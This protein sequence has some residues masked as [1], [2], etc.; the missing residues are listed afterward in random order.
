MANP[1]IIFGAGASYDYIRPDARYN[2]KPQYNSPITKDIFSKY[3]I[4]RSSPSY[5]EKAK[6]LIAHVVGRLS[7][8]NTFE[9]ILT[10]RFRRLDKSSRVVSERIA[11][12]FYLQQLFKVV[13]EEIGSQR[14]NNYEILID[15]CRSYLEENQGENIIC[16]TFNYDTLLDQA[17]GIP[18]APTDLEPYINQNI[19]LIKLH[20]SSNWS[21]YLGQTDE[22][23]GHEYPFQY[24]QDH[25]EIVADPQTTNLAILQKDSLNGERRDGKLVLYYPAIAIPLQGKDQF[26]CPADHVRALQ[27]GIETTD[28]IL[29]IGWRGNDDLLIN[30]IKQ[31]KNTK[32]LKILIVSSKP[33]TAREIIGQNLQNIPN[34]EVVASECF[35]FGAF[36]SSPELTSFFQ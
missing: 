18:Y 3:W 32:H 13:S 25:P 5:T 14:G 9:A 33:N 20:G 17:I 21:Y 30:A 8:T 1:I 2:H 4:E 12:S 6:D 31:R 10:Q 28:R 29:I 36:V 35:G 23:T 22:T 16:A 19:P 34:A 26:V 7:N 15:E 11:L 27:Q 24:F